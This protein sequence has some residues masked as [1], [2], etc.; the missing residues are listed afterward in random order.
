MGASLTMEQNH[1]GTKSPVTSDVLQFVQNHVL[2]VTDL[3]RT[4]KLSEILDSYADTVSDEIFVVQNGKNKNA[5]AVLS[6]LEY[7]QKLLK[8]QEIVEQAID[9]HMLEVT[10]KRKNDVGDMSIS[11]VLEDEDI[12]WDEVITC[13]DEIELED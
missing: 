8:Y 5:K 1:E 9:L 3:V 2:S 13:M 6:D 12:T 10:L 11:D 4:K 7:F